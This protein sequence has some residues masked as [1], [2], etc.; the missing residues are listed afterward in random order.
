[1]QKRYFNYKDDDSTYL[2]NSRL[3][4]ILDAGIYRGFDV[5]ILGGTMDLTLVQHLTGIKQYDNDVPMTEH[6]Y[7]VVMSPQGVTIKEDADVV[8][9]IVVTSTL[10]RIDIVVVEHKYDLVV[11]GNVAIY[12]VIQGVASN[13]PIKPDLTDPKTQIEVGSLILPINCV[14]LNQAGVIWTKNPPPEIPKPLRKYLVLNNYSALVSDYLLEIDASSNIIDIELVEPTLSNEGK[15]YEIDVYNAD[16]QITVRAF[17]QIKFEVETIINQSGDIWRY[18]F[19]N[20]YDLS[21]ISVGDKIKITN[22]DNIANNGFFDVLVVNNA[23]N[24]IDITNTLGI[25]ELSDSPCHI[26]ELIFEDKNFTTKDKK[27]Y[28]AYE[29]RNTYKLVRNLDYK[30]DA[31]GLPSTAGVGTID[32]N[33]I[34]DYYSEIPLAG[35]VTWGLTNIKPN[36][37]QSIDVKVSTYSVTLAQTGVIF[38]GA[39]NSSGIVQGLDETKSNLISIWAEASTVMWVTVINNEA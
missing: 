25:E 4:G 15:I 6:T 29:N 2:L 10:P 7:G 35:N 14:A 22:A 3:L 16:N 8:L 28:R 17:S 24:Y 37:L 27:V 12:K 34:N 11:G 30:P 21:R 5:E 39:V 1:M 19:N 33:R 20:T 18:T 32:F 36:L 13:E 23:L 31:D 38:K 26:Q 9:S